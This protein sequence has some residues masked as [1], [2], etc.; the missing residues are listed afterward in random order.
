VSRGRIPA[1]ENAGPSARTGRAD[2]RT[3]D[4]VL[5]A[6]ASA[7]VFG[8]LES[9][10]LLATARL[11]VLNAPY[12]VS[13][14]SLWIAP[15]VNALFFV[16]LAVL[17]G[18][19]IRPGLDRHG[20]LHGAAILF[21]VFSGVLAVFATAKVLHPVSAL[22]VAIGATAVL[23]R[24]RVGSPAAMAGLAR[25]HI[26]AAGVL[27]VAGAV[28]S[29]AWAPL[30]EAVAVRGLGAARGGA[31]NVL[32][33][34]LDTVRRD[35][36]FGELA[37]SLTPAL[38]RRAGGG[39]RY[40]NA[41]STSSW[42]LPTHGSLLTGL[43]AWEHGAHW[44]RLKLHSDVTTLPESFARAGYVTGAFSG[45][46]A[47]VV[48]AYVGRGFARF[49]V[50]STED[51]ARRTF[52]GRLLDRGLS[53][54]GFHYSGRGRKAPALNR[55]VLDF[56]A[57]HAERPFF[58]YVTYMD[59]NQ[60]MHHAVRR[61]PFWKPLGTNDEAVA[62]Y[63]RAL[64][65]LD[66]EIDALLDELDGRGLLENTLVVVVSDHGQSFGAALGDHPPAGHGTTLYAEQL[67][68]PLFVLTPRALSHE[69]NE[70][71]GIDQV[72]AA[73][74]RLAEAGFDAVAWPGV[75]AP[76]QPVIATL[77]YADHD[78]KAAVFDRWHVIAR[79]ANDSLSIE[80]Y[81]YV[82]DPH[83]RNDLGRRHA[84]AETAE[85]LLTAAGLFA[86]SSRGRA[87]RER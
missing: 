25:R 26:G 30:A 20:R 9:T 13:I 14:A 49:R 66:G 15:A 63:D 67:R 85:R 27:V 72:A 87:A 83:E 42:S 40:T 22:L 61:H 19:L 1:V 32:F 29:L 24:T 86:E 38:D 79:R 62:A 31:M 45:N 69:V 55:D 37:A 8:V 7:A 50:Y 64:T 70:P 74:L 81:D 57:D 33:L 41:W 76:A 84:A 65:E 21:L 48:P 51:I 82:A 11:P 23:A 43:P 35:R 68:V 3:A 78:E 16:P 17:L 2:S 58:A 12:K 54:L 47:W 4:L 80:V 71:V 56:V 5:V 53:A 6:L 46:S 28:V 52:Y 73:V 39:I 60:A 10:V 34:V 36:F 44:P 75:H 77:D 18:L 59:V